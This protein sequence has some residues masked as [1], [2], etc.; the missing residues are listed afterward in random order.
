[1]LHALSL[2]LLLPQQTASAVSSSFCAG[3]GW[4]QVWADEFS[5][6]KLNESAW[7][8]DLGGGDSRVRNSQGTRNNVYL[9]GGHLV[10]RSQRQKAGKYNYTSGA[11]ESR[12][13]VSW[14]GLTRACVRA[15]LPGGET[16]ATDWCA[17]TPVGVCRTGCPATTHALPGTCGPDKQPPPQGHSCNRCECNRQNT[18]CPQ[19]GGKRPDSK[20]VWPAHWMMPDNTACWPSN[21]EIDIM[22]MVNGDGVTHATYHWREREIGVAYAA[23]HFGILT[24]ISLCNVCSCHE[25]HG[26]N[27]PAQVAAVTSAVME[28]RANTQAMERPTRIE[29]TARSAATTSSRSFSTSHTT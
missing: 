19:D 16:P 13:K 12:G 15:K 26:H 25:I 6:T 5:G 27:G 4:R 23:P 7:S 18:T 22:E 1:M 17:T 21:G 3:E 20:G 24:G 8:I 14:R 11:V 28:A 2:A 9:E 29:A 10:L